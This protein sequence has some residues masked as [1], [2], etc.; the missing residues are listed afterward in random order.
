MIDVSDG[1]LIDL[2]YGLENQ[3]VAIAAYFVLTKG[4][5]ETELLKH[6]GNGQIK[7]SPWRVS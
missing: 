5:A 7:G 1:L 2:G 3:Y 6:P 4:T